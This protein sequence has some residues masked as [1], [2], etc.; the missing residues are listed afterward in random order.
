MMPGPTAALT[1]PAL[2]AGWVYEG[3]VVDA[4]GPISTGRFTAADMADDDA[5]GPDAG[6]DGTPPFPGQDFIDPALSLVGL[7]AVISVEPE[8]DDS[9]APFA[10][11]PLIDAMV[12]DVGAGVTQSMDDPGAIPDGMASIVME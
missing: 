6:P 7:T 5:G 2:P 1:L 9:P 4:N 8:D 12:E 3:W 11:K 10:I